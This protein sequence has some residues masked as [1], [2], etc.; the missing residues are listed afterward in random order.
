MAVYVARRCLTVLP[1]V[2]GVSLLVFAMLQ[3]LPG[4]P[5]EVIPGEAQ[6]NPD[7]VSRLRAALGWHA[8]GC[9]SGRTYDSPA[10]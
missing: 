1:V 4:D 8:P 3:V 7:Q 6:A 10:T 5:A 9:L 2:F